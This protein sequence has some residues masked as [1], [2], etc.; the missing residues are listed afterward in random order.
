MDLPVIFLCRKDMID[1]IHFDTRQHKH[2]EWEK[3]KPGELRE[4]LANRIAAI[5]GERPSKD[6]S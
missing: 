6:D 4:K 2:I 1:E 5:I 3:E